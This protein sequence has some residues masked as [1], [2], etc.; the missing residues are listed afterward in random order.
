MA[1]KP[2]KKA[3]PK[4]QA[5]RTRQ[6]HED[7]EELDATLEETGDVVPE[8]EKPSGPPPGLKPNE[9]IAWQ[10]ANAGAKPESETE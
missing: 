8:P 3:A 4:K 9:L 2:A 1:H 6:M 5:G 10:Q 7:S